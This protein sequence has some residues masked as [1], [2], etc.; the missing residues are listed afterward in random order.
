M[1]SVITL[2]AVRTEQTESF[3]KTRIKNLFLLPVLIAGLGLILAGRAMAQPYTFGSEFQST[4]TASITYNSTTGVFQYTD[5]ANLSDDIAGLPLTGNAATII[6]NSNGWSASLT[7]NLSTTTMTSTTNE[8]PYNGMGLFI[9]I[10]GSTK[11]YVEI[12]LNQQN[13]TGNLIV[14]NPNIYG[15]AA[16]LKAVVNGDNDATT[17]LGGSQNVAGTSFL[18]ISGGSGSSP[19]T[20]SINAASGVLTFTNNPSTGILTGYFN[21]SPVGSVSLADWGNNLSLTLYVAGFS[22]EGVGV[23]SGTDPANNFSTAS[24]SVIPRLIVTTTSLPKGTNGTVYNSTLAASGGQ[25]PYSWTNM[26]G[27]LP[28]GL[29]LATNGVISGTPPTNGTNNFTVKVTDALS[30]TA[31]QALSL[32]VFSPPIVT[33]QPTNT[34]IGVPDGGNLTL[35][36]SVTGTGPF[37][38][39]WQLNSNNLL[40][41]IITTVA[42]NGQEGYPGNGVLATNTTL[43]PQGVVVDDNGNLFIVNFQ[44]S[45]DSLTAYVSK[46]Q[47]NGIITTVAGGGS[48][49]LYHY[50]IYPTN[51]IPATNAS[52]TSLV[53]LTV[54][55]NGNLFVVDQY[56]EQIYKVDNNGIITT[57]A[58]VYSSSSNGGYNG[59]GIAATNAELHTPVGVAV[60]TIGNLFIADSYNQRIR[61]VGINGIITTVAGSGLTGYGN[62]SYSGDGDAATNAEL[63]NPTGVAV[64]ASGNLF[65]TDQNNDRIR[66][67]STNGII[68]TVAGNGTNNYTGDRGAATNA[69]LNLNGW[70]YGPSGVAVGTA[71]NLFIADSGNNVIREVNSNGII[72]T[73]AGGGS[74]GIGDGGVATS[75]ELN[76]PL[77]V[78]V[79]AS[80][81]LFIADIYNYL[82]RKVVFNS[83][84][85][86]PT[87]VLNNVNIGNSGAYDLVVT[88]PY[89]SVTSSVVNVTVTLPPLVLSMPQII[90]NSMTAELSGPAGS[91][92]VVQISTNLFNWT[93]VVTST[94]PVGGSINLTDNVDVPITNYNRRFYRVKYQ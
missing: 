67:V 15:T 6:T 94:I 56:S 48:G 24:W 49:N 59:D 86:S 71:G 77:G 9:L 36:V 72:T 13:S 65:I 74:N 27:S 25:M 61:K 47:A 70:L 52:F 8:A 7:A 29:K 91:N 78:A 54:D 46:V 33:I 90:G 16:V 20:Q 11:N 75:A 92:Y 38:Y 1:D 50:G 10:N 5:T 57:V 18:E 76:Y 62:G 32:I 84:V 41:S 53:G 68:T 19:S 22:G 42:G 80:G 2:D 82:V 30:A 88:G 21:G 83:S 14:N 43:Y 40:N 28:T 4:N 64:D 73:V 81:N 39:Q 35:A 85:L 34:S 37:T 60:D 63:N 87:L 89:G 58:G 12:T 23:S 51:G 45:D 44:F 31:T 26:S 69:E 55:L 79:D 17:P 3:M 66:K 93:S